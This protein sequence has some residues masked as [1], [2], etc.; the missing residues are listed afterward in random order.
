MAGEQEKQGHT[1]NLYRPNKR[2]HIV[3]PV[4]VTVK[5]LRG[6]IQWSAH[7]NSF[8]MRRAWKLS[9]KFRV[10]ITAQI[11][12]PVTMEFHST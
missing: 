8:S 4:L 3:F 2:N 10:Q 12:C 1:I 6:E 9:K 11:Q 7:G 5:I